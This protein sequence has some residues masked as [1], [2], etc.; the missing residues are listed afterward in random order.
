MEPLRGTLLQLHDLNSYNYRLPQAERIL[1]LHN[2]LMQMHTLLT[3][4][5]TLHNIYRSDKNE[6]QKYPNTASCFSY[7]QTAA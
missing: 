7:P 4:R 2:R 6:H 1:H 5:V 3:R